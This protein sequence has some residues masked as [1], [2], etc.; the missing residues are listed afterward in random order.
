MD[1][2][3]ISNNFCVCGTCNFLCLLVDRILSLN[4]ITRMIFLEKVRDVSGDC[5]PFVKEIKNAN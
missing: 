1:S 4:P 2:F 3:S 5:Y